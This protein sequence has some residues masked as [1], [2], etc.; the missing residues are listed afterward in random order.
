MDKQIAFNARAVFTWKLD[1]LYR[2]Y[3]STDELLFIRIGG[4]GG[5]QEGILGGLHGNAIGILFVPIIMLF[6]KLFEKKRR[7]KIET[8]DKKDPRSLV[9][10]HKHNFRATLT[11]FE[12]ASIEPPSRLAVHGFHAGRWKFTLRNKGKMNLQFETLHDM[13]VALE[14]LPKLLG[15]S[16]KINVRKNPKS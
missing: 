13:N 8:A 9:Y 5:V 2:V 10:T 6:T 12:D 14:V 4:Q 15:A 11:D 16:L 1:R 3:V 7:A